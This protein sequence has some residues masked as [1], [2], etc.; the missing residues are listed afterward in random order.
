MGGGVAAHLAAQTVVGKQVAV[1]DFRPCA[2]LGFTVTRG[3]VWPP[4]AGDLGNGILSIAQVPMAE[5]SDGPW[6][7][8]AKEEVRIE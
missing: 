4:Q 8:D 1:A 5:Q 6:I 3:G 7:G 2:V